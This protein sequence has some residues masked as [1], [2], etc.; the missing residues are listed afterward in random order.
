MTNGVC[1]I[2][3]AGKEGFWLD[4]HSDDLKAD[5]IS[6]Y[7]KNK[8]ITPQNKEIGVNNMMFFLNLDL[9][10]GD[11]LSLRYKKKDYKIYDFANSKETAIDGA[12]HEKITICRVATAKINGVKI[13]D[14]YNNILKVKVD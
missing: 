6:F 1:G 9:K 4:I 7:F 8:K 3:V 5:D 14:V 11:T 13:A 12:N 10:L 2:F